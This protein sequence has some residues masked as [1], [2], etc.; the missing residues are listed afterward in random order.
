ME[1]KEVSQEGIDEEVKRY[2][3]LSGCPQDFI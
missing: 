3:I 1:R 2:L